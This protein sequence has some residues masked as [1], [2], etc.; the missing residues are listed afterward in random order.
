MS[1]IFGYRHLEI[2]LEDDQGLVTVSQELTMSGP[3]VAFNYAF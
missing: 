1:A 3:F 2:D